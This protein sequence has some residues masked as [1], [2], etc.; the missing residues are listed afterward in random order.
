MLKN[1]KIDYLINNSEKYTTFCDYLRFTIPFWDYEKNS[2][3]EKLQEI[4]KYTDK[5]KFIKNF[6]AEWV[7]NKKFWCKDIYWKDV[8]F[9]GDYM[10]RGAKREEK[11]E[12][13]KLLKAFYYRIFYNIDDDNSN[14]QIVK[15]WWH[16]ITMQKKVFGN[17][18][19]IIGSVVYMG[20]SH[21]VFIIEEFNIYTKKM[22]GAWGKMDFYGAFWRLY[23]VW[24]LEKWCWMSEKWLSWLE[25]S[26]FDYKIDLWNYK[27]SKNGYVSMNYFFD[28][29]EKATA[30]YGFLEKKEIKKYWKW[31]KIHSWKIWSSDNKTCVIR[32][33]DKKKDSE[34]KW[35][36][37]LYGDYFEGNNKVF[38][39]EWE[40]GNKFCKEYQ[41]EN[42]NQLQ[43]K[44]EKYL[45]LKKE[46]FE[47]KFYHTYEK[48]DL[49][50]E[51]QATR[52]FKSFEGYLKGLID[53]NI[54][55][56]QF[57]DRVMKKKWFSEKEV[58]YAFFYR[59]KP[60]N[61]IKDYF[62]NFEKWKI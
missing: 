25:I 6:N 32:G 3:I 47:W 21:P 58:D 29:R 40:F 54:N 36:F 14:Y 43:N 34:K 59:K 22:T 31:L 51:V 35:K 4:K 5:I 18:S 56:Y 44:I 60:L 17:G 30:E 57:V 15:I 24:F 2:Q 8:I 41:F 33:Y 61:D 23:E 1:W 37:A 13:W 49:S 55:P 27:K 62:L 53:N 52:Y 10:W 16:S 9:E 11:T 20:E 19:C 38:R 46:K 45:R 50:N 48:V 7:K 12:V 39:L 42:F 26:R 28:E